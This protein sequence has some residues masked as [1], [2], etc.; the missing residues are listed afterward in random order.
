MIH[1]ILL[2]LALL[3]PPS[4]QAP[5]AAKPDQSA[6]QQTPTP[7][8]VRMGG[9]VT[10]KFL[11]KKVQPH[12]PEEARANR[13]QG[14]VKLHAIIATDGKIKSLELMSGD[15]ILAKAAIEAV[16]QW[17]YRTTLFNGEPVEVDTTVDV[18]FSLNE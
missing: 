15:E 14:T 8:R 5:D 11:K 18:V 12:Y 17:E 6:P 3:A 2:S 13:I 10:V 1:T 16:R 9:N 4:T 7:K